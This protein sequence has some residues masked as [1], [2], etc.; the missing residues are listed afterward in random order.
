MLDRCGTLGGDTG[1][2]TVTVGGERGAESEVVET[3][4]CSILEFCCRRGTGGVP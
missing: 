4:R 3:G 2:F 1:E